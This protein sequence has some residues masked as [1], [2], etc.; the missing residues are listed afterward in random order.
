MTEG[1]QETQQA[2]Q[3]LENNA[4]SS[5]DIYTQQPTS[6]IESNVQ[7]QVTNEGEDK[8]GDVI[9]KQDSEAKDDTTEKQEQINREELDRRLREYELDKTEREAL[10]NRLGLNENLSQEDVEYISLEQQVTNRGKMAY[11]DL[12]NAYGVDSDPRRIDDSLAKL[13][14]TDPAKGYEFQRHLENLTQDVTAQKQ[15]IMFHKS[16]AGAQKFFTEYGQVL[17]SSPM[18]AQT[19]SQVYQANRGNPNIYNQLKLTIDSLAN[20]YREAYNYGRSFNAM[21]TAK[22]DTSGVEGSIT[23]T[24]NQTAKNSPRKYTRADIKNMSQAEFERRHD[25]IMR[26]YANGEIVD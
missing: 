26:M 14:A 8:P 2:P 4:F 3:V 23:E 6:D 16:E 19:L 7:S 12:C 17:Q 11:L 15:N 24:V 13:K 9:E 18:L 25:E 5:E 10:R 1:I 20:V 22:T 21:N